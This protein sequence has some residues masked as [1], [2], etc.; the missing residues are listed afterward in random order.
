MTIYAD[1]NGQIS[2]HFTIPAGIP[3]GCKRVQA[4]GAGGSYAETTFTGRGTVLLRELQYIYPP[5]FFVDPL[6]QT[7][8]VDEDILCSGADFKFAAKGT[9]DPIVQIREVVNG[10]PTTHVLAQGTL[11]NASLSIDPNTWTRFTWPA[12]LLEHGVEYALSIACN[13]AVM[14]IRHAGLGEYDSYHSAWVTQQ[15]YTIGVMMSSS[16]GTT[17]T[18]DQFKDMTFRLIQPTFTDT[19]YT[20]SIT[21][22]PV[23]VT[24]ADYLSVLA[25]VLRPF[26]TTNVV[27]ELTVPTTP[28]AT[29]YTVIEGQ[30]IMLPQSVTGEVTWRAI[31]TGTAHVSPWMFRSVQLAAGTCEAA[32][33]YVS[34][35]FPVNSDGTTLIVNLLAVLPSPST[36]AVY[37]QTNYGDGS[38]VPAW[39]SALSAN[40][41]PRAVG[42]CWYE[43]SYIHASLSAVTHTRLKLS[44]A[45]TARA[46][47]Q[48][49]GLQCIA[50]DA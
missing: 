1:A 42:G 32:G 37:V 25:G 18:A 8:Q 36:L 44:L 10:I 35:A 30:P 21:M 16:N 41:S 9:T 45:G 7:F 33:T 5:T 6:A 12:I 28:T 3:A 15:P 34:R 4:Y 49:A 31:L 50:K 20:R 14:S 47:P 2:K 24:N 46:R 17:W 43:R 22:T 23:T 19:N 40:G 38:E 13:D 11:P 39:S 29:V 48:V 26:S 27:F